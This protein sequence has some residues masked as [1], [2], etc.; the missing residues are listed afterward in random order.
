M[1]EENLKLV[2]E[3][4][5]ENRHS[6]VYLLVTAIFALIVVELIHFL[7][8]LEPVKGQLYYQIDFLYVLLPQVIALASSAY[9]LFDIYRK[10]L[11]LFRETRI[12]K[13]VTV[14]AGFSILSGIY[15]FGFANLNYWIFV[16]GFNL[17]VNL[18][19]NVPLYF[20]VR[21][22]L[23]EANIKG[24]PGTYLLKEIK[25]WIFLTIIYSV[26]II[27]IGIGY[28]LL[29]E[30]M[31]EA[32]FFIRQYTNWVGLLA[33]IC[34]AGAKYY[35]TPSRQARPLLSR[36]RID[37]LKQKLGEMYSLQKKYKKLKAGEKDRSSQGPKSKRPRDR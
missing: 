12:G 9:L 23:N 1:T 34:A 14:V 3:V 30:A 36:K 16:M 10:I 13:I 2:S 6:A 37:E 24:E 28:A 11:L 22:D 20:S 26:V 31:E 5:I 21:S 29:M 35:W 7:V 4:E 15:I 27:L 19:K 18:S 33:F 8:R 17:A 25:E 32:H